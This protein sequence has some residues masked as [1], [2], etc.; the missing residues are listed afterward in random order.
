MK[1]KLTYKIT[2]E[3]EFEKVTGKFLDYGFIILRDPY[4]S[5]TDI[6]I[7][8]NEEIFYKTVLTSNI[9]KSIQYA[10]KIIKNDIYKR[11]KDFNSEKKIIETYK[12]YDCD[13]LEKLIKGEC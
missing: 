13:Y 10:A 11:V 8:R 4:D 1:N 12:K 3:F 7:Y 6:W 2:E 9:N 5:E